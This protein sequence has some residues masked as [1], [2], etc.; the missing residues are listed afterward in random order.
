MVNDKPQNQTTSRLWE[1]A[2]TAL[3]RRDH[4]MGRMRQEPQ[5]VE[6]DLC[7]WKGRR[8]KPRS[9]PCPSCGNGKVQFR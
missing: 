6:C 7:G 2:T 4:E 3:S 5:P 1:A 9:A 8:I